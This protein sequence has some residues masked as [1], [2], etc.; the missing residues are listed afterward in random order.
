MAVFGELPFGPE[1]AGIL[2]AFRINHLVPL[3]EIVNSVRLRQGCP[4]WRTFVS[5]PAAPPVTSWVMPRV[6][7]AELGDELSLKCS[8]IGNKQRAL[9][10]EK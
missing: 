5:S 9:I 7:R 6:H 4:F 1:T 10:R 2:E 3:V 8:N